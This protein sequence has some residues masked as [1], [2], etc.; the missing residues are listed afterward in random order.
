MFLGK[1]GGAVDAALM[2]AG[3]S[4]VEIF[5]R[6]LHPVGIAYAM[7][8]R[9]YNAAAVMAT[10]RDVGVIGSPVILFE[11][12]LTRFSFADSLRTTQAHF[13]AT[14]GVAA[15]ATERRKMQETYTLVADTMSL[16][17]TQSAELIASWTG[18]RG[19][20][21]L[22]NAMR[23][24]YSLTPVAV[25]RAMSANGWSL[26]GVMAGLAMTHAL[27]SPADLIPALR[28][29]GFG[30]L[31][32]MYAFRP[33]SLATT[34]RTLGYGA[35]EFAAYHKAQGGTATGAA[36]F[37]ASSGFDN[38]AVANT[39]RAS[40]GVANPAAAMQLMTGGGATQP[41]LD[42]VAASYGVDPVLAVIRA[43]R[44]TGQTAHMAVQTMRQR[45][46]VTDR[47]AIMEKLAAAGYP[48]LDVVA[49]FGGAPMSYAEILG[50][51]QSAYNE[52]PRTAYL[53]EQRSKG[54]AAKTGILSLQ[55][56]GISDAASVGQYLA[57][58]G[59]TKSQ[60]MEAIEWQYRLF[61]TLA[62]VLAAVYS[63]S[64]E[65]ALW[66]VIQRYGYQPKEALDYMALNAGPTGCYT[67]STICQP[68]AVA[69]F[70]L[71]EMYGLG[72]T[73]A[74]DLL[75]GS[76]YAYGPQG[77]TIADVQAEYGDAPGPIYA[78]ALKAGGLYGERLRGHLRTACFP[79]NCREP[80]YSYNT[81]FAVA[82][83][84]KAGG[85][86]ADQ[87][88]NAIPAVYSLAGSVPVNGILDISN[89]DNSLQARLYARVLV[90]LFGFNDAGAVA[91]KLLKRTTSEHLLGA[92]QPYFPSLSTG[93]K[94]VILAPSM[95]R[96]D[97][98]ELIRSQI[99]KGKLPRRD[100]S[101][102]SSLR[103]MGF[104]SSEAGEILY[105]MLGFDEVEY[106]LLMRDQS[107]NDNELADALLRYNPSLNNLSATLAIWNTYK[108]VF[109]IL[110]G[111][112]R[113]GEEAFRTTAAAVRRWRGDD[114]WDLYHAL[115]G[116][117][118][119]AVAIKAMKD[120]GASAYAVLEVI[121][122][123]SAYRESLSP[124]VIALRRAGYSLQDLARALK[125]R[126]YDM[127][128]MALLVLADASR[129]EVLSLPSGA[130]D[131]LTIAFGPN[132]A[133]KLIAM[134]ALREAGID[135]YK[136]TEFCV[137]LKF[138]WKVAAMF[139]S[140]SGY[141]TWDGFQAVWKRWGQII[142]WEAIQL[143]LP[144]WQLISI[145][146]PVILVIQALVNRGLPPE[147]QAP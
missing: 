98:K 56:F 75:A 144:N 74:I 7:A 46:L 30:I 111:I 5:R 126:Y 119:Q 86:D 85:Y 37:L 107:Y 102:A 103:A 92:L 50:A 26:E 142:L 112:G 94:L 55:R 4:N 24:R 57:D 43:L 127:S 25:G 62:R 34:L 99:A 79:T 100:T 141:P 42:A 143:I 53:L 77:F 70:I 135:A 28:E 115:Y 38:F 32:V 90:E 113:T 9:G 11:A 114:W 59:Y 134:A 118:S 45:Y 2:A 146:F 48:I 6:Y 72:L 40:Y 44:E 108:S 65:E 71:H 31:Q 52:D 125:T 120:G 61:P 47:T 95:T 49:A 139:L 54:A 51:I 106:A 136:A 13:G 83:I 123:S 41:V 145:P 116:R 147:H 122:G 131:E 101:V 67:P 64:G 18:R 138:S 36:Q 63:L 81:E 8:E 39:L 124:K 68:A 12:L 19:E 20:G 69:L 60:V 89:S 29:T 117:V 88:L 80:Y 73:A 22:L 137:D 15:A 87:V 109:N 33:E 93:T 110:T 1:P 129:D 17:A 23:A 140:F 97:L 35:Q 78:A 132:G 27:T 14:V 105:K 130:P 16:T 76:R 21:Q 96:G 3:F 10:I 84:L 91:G 58:A 82:G 66:D 128:S 104:I 121:A 133:G